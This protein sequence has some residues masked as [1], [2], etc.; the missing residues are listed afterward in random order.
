[1]TL[2]INDSSRYA[3]AIAEW[4]LSLAVRADA[5]VAEIDVLHGDI[6]AADDEAVCLASFRSDD[7]AAGMRRA[8]TD[9]R[10][11]A[12][13]LGRIAAAARPTACRV[14]WGACP[15]H[16][17]TLT[18]SGG[19][20]WCRYGGCVGTWDWDRVGLPCTE[21]ARW[22]VTDRQGGESVMCHGHALDARRCLEGA[23]VELREEFA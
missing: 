13:H 9:L 4:A 10:E 12:G 6:R 11:T 7:A 14:Q 18:S 22:K 8:A 20:T 16:G 19:K 2:K 15:Q 17:N 21:P 1:M 23:R 5:L 3:R